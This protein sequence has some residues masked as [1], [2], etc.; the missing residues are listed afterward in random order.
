MTATRRIWA[1]TVSFSDLGA[2]SLE[3]GTLRAQMRVVVGY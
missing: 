2:V 3:S 1:R